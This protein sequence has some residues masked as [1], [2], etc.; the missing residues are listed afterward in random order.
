MK[1]E[2]KRMNE[3]KRTSETKRTDET[4]SDTKRY[5]TTLELWA[6]VMR[7]TE[8][9]MPAIR[10]RDHEL[11]DQCARA[12]VKACMALGEAD[13]RRGGNRRQRLREADGEM[14]ELACGLR[15][16]AML[17][18]LDAEAVETAVALVERARAMTT[19]RLRRCA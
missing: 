12:R 13:G 8:T 4:K 1:N 5:R 6:D 17:G 7:K 15:M 2:T 11:G 14:A 16:A 19:S 9:L 18:Y 3:T 10:R